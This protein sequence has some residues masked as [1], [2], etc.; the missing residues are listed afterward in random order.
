MR[1]TD[2]SFVLYNSPSCR[3]DGKLEFSLFGKKHNLV[4]LA[5]PFFFHHKLSWTDLV[6]T[7]LLQHEYFSWVFSQS[8]NFYVISKKKS[9]ELILSYQHVDTQEKK[10]LLKKE[11][12]YN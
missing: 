6:T 7:K 4:L 9:H 11:R 3:N 12:E 10:K 5:D 2:S 1:P 8:L